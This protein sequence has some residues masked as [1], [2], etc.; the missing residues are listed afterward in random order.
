NGAIDDVDSSFR[1]WS[2]ARAASDLADDD[3]K[4]GPASTPMTTP[5]RRALAIMLAM[6]V[7]AG[8]ALLST[9]ISTRLRESARAEALWQGRRLLESARDDFSLKLREVE[10]RASAAASLNPIRA[11]VAQRVDR[12]TFADAFQSEEWWRPFRDEFPV[13]ILVL[14]EKRFDFGTDAAGQL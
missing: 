13:T 3:R 11:L 6:V 1:P 4:T 12:A 14:G 10:S 5:A 8:A 9:S 7:L 2:V